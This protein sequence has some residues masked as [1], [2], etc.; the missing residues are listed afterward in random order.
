MTDRPHEF[1]NF[2]PSTAL[3]ADPE[4]GRA[5]GRKGDFFRIED[6]DRLV[7]PRNAVPF[8]QG[9]RFI[10]ARA[11]A[12]PGING[13]EGR[14]RLVELALAITFGHM[15]M[16]DGPSHPKEPRASRGAH[17]DNNNFTVYRWYE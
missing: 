6:A 7:E 13:T 10:L 5:E 11:V 2:Q 9:E 14:N 4:M 17:R 8:S 12:L 3:V 1:P 16:L 15:S